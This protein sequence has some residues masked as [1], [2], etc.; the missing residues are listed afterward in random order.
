[1]FFRI[2]C[3]S[4][5]PISHLHTIPIERCAF[6]YALVTDAP[7]CFPSLFIRSLVEIHRSSSKSHGLFFLVFIHRILLHLGLEDF[8][9][10]KPVHIIAPIGAIFLRQRVAQMKVSSKHPRVESSSS[11]T[12]QPPSIAEEFVDPT[13]AVDPPPSSSSDS[14]IR[15]M[16]DTVMTVQVAHG[17]LLVDVLTELQALCT[18]L[19]SARRSCPP[20]P[21]DDEPWLSFGNL[22]QKGGVHIDG[23][24]GSFVR[25]Y[26]GVLWCIFFFGS[27]C[28]FFGL[29]VFIFMGCIC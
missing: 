16:L 29:D 20:P 17:Q 12:S 13:A 27:W 7:M 18:N 6:L 3:Y 26:L 4:I 23:D 15:S 14:F 1:M 21:F 19:A 2:S 24:R 9:A 8:P 5:W 25:L 28:I 10:F 11:A 22:S